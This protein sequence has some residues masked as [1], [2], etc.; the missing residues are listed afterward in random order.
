MLLLVPVMLAQQGLALADVPSYVALGTALFFGES[1][2]TTTALE[3]C[4]PA[5]YLLF[6]IVFNI[7]AICTVSVVGAATMT[8]ASTAS[9]PLAIW[10]FTLTWPLLGPAAPLGNTFVA[11]ASLLLAGVLLYNSQEIAQ[12][13]GRYAGNA[14][15]TNHGPSAEPPYRARL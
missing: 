12:V 2:Y 6:N 15:G 13:F 5:I 10:A 4:I 9:I 8:L 14:S 7:V 1:Q 11:G 3:A